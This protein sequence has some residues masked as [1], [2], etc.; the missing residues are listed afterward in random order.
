M[1]SQTSLPKLKKIKISI[2]RISGDSMT[3]L[4]QP[5]NLVLAVYPYR[6]LVGDIVIFL[7]NNIE[8]IKRVENINENQ[9]YVV[10]ENKNSSTDSRSFG[11]IDKNL[12]IGKVIKFR[13]M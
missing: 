7:H 4:Y 10:G 9:A 3:P 11:W 12:I 2:R 6:I 5:G 8:K 1:K 13:R